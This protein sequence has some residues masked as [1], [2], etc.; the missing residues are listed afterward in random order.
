MTS[1]TSPQNG[2]AAG[3]EVSDMV[4]EGDE[5]QRQRVYRYILNRGNEGATN[6]ETQKALRIRA[7]SETARC[8]ELQTAGLVRDSGRSRPNE[9]GTGVTVYV[10]TRKPLS[11]DDVDPAPTTAERDK[12]PEGQP[13]VRTFPG[14]RPPNLALRKA[15]D[16]RRTI[17]DGRAQKLSDEEITAQLQARGLSWP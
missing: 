15:A 14:S 12:P 8:R 16:A 11:L 13:A 10:A 17:L 1:P 2:T 4:R 5:T 3:R 9:F 7:S 6:E